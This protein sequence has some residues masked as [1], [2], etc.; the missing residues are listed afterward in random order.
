MSIAY[1]N[2][3]DAN[4]KN[5]VFGVT[6]SVMH[7]EKRQPTS[8]VFFDGVCN[9]CNGLID[10]MI[11]SHPPSGF[12]VASL[13]GEAAEKHLPPEVRDS[14]ST[15]IFWKEGSIEKRSSAAISALAE[16]PGWKW[17]RILKLVPP[18]LRDAA[19]DF[20]AR[21]RYRLFG[22]RESCRLPT[23]EERKYFLD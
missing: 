7:G 13:Q 17:V 14:L 18:F 22:K 10:F 16:L 2:E 20:I 12:F 19:Y 8:I 15:V 3:P 6:L 23:P 5:G 9:L 11:R 21:N 1:P 4:W